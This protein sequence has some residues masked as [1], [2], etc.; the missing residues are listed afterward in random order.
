[1]KKYIVLFTA[2]ATAAELS[3]N[4][5]SLQNAV[6]TAWTFATV[7]QADGPLFAV[8]SRVSVQM[9]GFS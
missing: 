8:L 9:D 1:M 4:E 5:F 6:E 2:L 3:L 7:G